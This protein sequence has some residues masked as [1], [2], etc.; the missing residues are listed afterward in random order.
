MADIKNKRIL[1]SNLDKVI[2]SDKTASNK[3][4]SERILA[5]DLKNKKIKKP[6]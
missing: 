1:G 3:R 4:K 6:A 2:N 5:A